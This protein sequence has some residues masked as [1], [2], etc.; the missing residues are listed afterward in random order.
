MCANSGRDKWVCSLR[1]Q[2]VGVFKM[3]KGFSH[4]HFRL[5]RTR[6]TG[7]LTRLCGAG[8]ADRKYRT[9]DYLLDVVWVR[10]HWNCAP[11]N[12]NETRT[13]VSM[14]VLDDD[15]AHNSTKITKNSI[16]GCVLHAH[17]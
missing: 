4:W 10:L 8:S 7:N 15:D 16:Y 17:L 5:K 6:F 1:V 9:R 11:L 14:C 13:Q 12:V 2:Q 3:T